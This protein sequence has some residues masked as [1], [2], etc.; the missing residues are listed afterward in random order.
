MSLRIP[1]SS[2]EFMLAHTVDMGVYECVPDPV[3]LV[4]V[5]LSK[6]LSIWASESECAVGLKP[7]EGT[8]T[9]ARSSQSHTRHCPLW[10]LNGNQP[11]AHPSS[12]GWA[13]THGCSMGFWEA[14]AGED[15]L[16]VG[17][18]PGTC[19]SIL[20]AEGMGQ[21]ICLRQWAFTAVRSLLTLT[22]LGT[23]QTTR[24]GPLCADGVVVTDRMCACAQRAHRISKHH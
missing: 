2:P 4:S 8:G 17:G 6:S 15:G 20:L 9:N 3:C 13:L 7:T 21:L 22:V 12:R 18:A 11:W 14:T 24:E 5:S 10:A 19:F 16:L 23:A 1:V